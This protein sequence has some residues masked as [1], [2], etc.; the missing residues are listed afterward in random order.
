M[1]VLVD[2][3]VWSLALRRK[4]QASHSAVNQLRDIILDGHTI[5]Y[6]GIILTELLHGIRSQSL[7]EQ[8]ET[9][10]ETFTCLDLARENY[11]N[12]ARLSIVC[13]RKGITA[14]TIDFIIATA[15]IDNA[16]LLLTTDK[17][18]DSIAKV[19]DLK[20]LKC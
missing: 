20:L 6:I 15:A 13:K 12:A 10:F 1:N 17:D 9:Q 19:S 14:S 2:T 4:Q 5:L 3:S 7:F 8:I 11:V 18:F 16:C